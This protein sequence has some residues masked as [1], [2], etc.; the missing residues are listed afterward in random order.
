MNRFKALI[1]REFWENK[2]AFRTTPLVIGAIYVV[3]LCMAMFTP[4]HFDDGLYT[5]RDA[6]MKMGEQSEELRAAIMYQGTLASSLLFTMAMSFVIFFYLLGALYDDRKDRSILFWK[7]LPA[8]D[9]QTIASKLFCAMVLVPLIFFAAMVATHIVL[10]IVGSIM[11][12]IIG[13][14]P[15]DVF[16]SVW[17]P[18][19]AWGMIGAGWAA[20]SIWAIPAYGWL[21]LV[22]AFAPRLPLLFA[23]LPPLVLAIL[24]S[25][26]EFLRT[27]TLQ[28]NIF[29]VVTTWIANSPV[30]LSVQFDGEHGEIAL[31]VPS[32]FTQDFDHTVTIGNMLDRLFSMQMLAGLL[33]GTV[34]LAGALWLRRRATE[35]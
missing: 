23:T 6:I 32:P 28:D 34:F 22:S 33:V 14:S 3:G 2:G 9:L 21:L 29:G 8:S 13:A 12:M 30:I 5:H 15:W 20:Q 19:K 18:F 11:I 31:G 16:L 25:W 17:N 10:A 7:S 24:Q 27:F 1:Q 35:N 4:A 26:I